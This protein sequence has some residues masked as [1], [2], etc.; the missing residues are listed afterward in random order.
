MYVQMGCADQGLGGFGSFLNKID[1]KLRP[2]EKIAAVAA[3]AMYAPAMLPMVA[4]AA[5]SKGAPVDNGSVPMTAPQS[6][7]SATPMQKASNDAIVQYQASLGPSASSVPL[8]PPPMATS[9]QN[10]RLLMYGGLG[11]GALLLVLML[12]RRR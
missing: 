8:T 11:L 9:D 4:G 2:L 5:L 3:T 12:S 10:K 7:A 1:K 6:V